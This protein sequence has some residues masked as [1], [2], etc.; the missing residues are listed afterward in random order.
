MFCI[1]FKS[2]EEFL[3]HSVICGIYPATDTLL[4]FERKPSRG[5]GACLLIH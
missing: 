1:Q 2:V 5:S 4:V 3:I